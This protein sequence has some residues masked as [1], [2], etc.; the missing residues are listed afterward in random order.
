MLTDSLLDFLHLYACPT[1]LFNLKGQIL[2]ANRAAEVC[3]GGDVSTEVQAQRAIFGSSPTAS[4]IAG[5]HN[6]NR[7]I[8]SDIQTTIRAKRVILD[9]EDE[10]HNDD[11]QPQQHQ[12]QPQQ[13]HR[14]PQPHPDQSQEDFGFSFAASPP[15]VGGS[16]PAPNLFIFPEPSTSA[17]SDS[18]AAPTAALSSIPTLTTS[19]S[20]SSSSSSSTA[21]GSSPPGTARQS[22]NASRT[23]HNNI[24]GRLGLD[25]NNGIPEISRGGSYNEAT[26]PGHETATLTREDT[27]TTIH[28]KVTRTKCQRVVAIA[29]ETPTE[30]AITATEADLLAVRKLPPIIRIPWQEQPRFQPLKMG[31][32]LMGDR[33]RN[34]DWANHP[35]GPIDSWPQARIEMVGLILRSPV[36]MTAYMEDPAYVIYNDPYIAVLGKT[37][38]NAG[39]A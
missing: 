24:S 21:G 6:D 31:G 7:R 38:H 36:P 15:A 23:Q 3:D 39:C 17:S 34:F 14:H 5:K 29:Q 2:Y 25:T 32:G 10:Q 13:L 18:H 26:L 35:L 27:T 4:N 8:P 33:I 20:S 1:L 37:K 19:S 28:W 22:D 11:G 9:Q 30:V 16:L 12:H